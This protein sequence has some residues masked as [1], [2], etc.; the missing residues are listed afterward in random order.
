MYHAVHTF[1]DH[2]VERR[3]APR[4]DDRPQFRLIFRTVAVRVC[5]IKIEQGRGPCV[6]EVNELHPLD[7]ALAAGTEE[8]VQLPVRQ[9]KNQS[10]DTG[11]D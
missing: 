11:Y 5:E 8:S 9:A 4:L 1:P 7:R 3:S 2:L 10:R 6:A